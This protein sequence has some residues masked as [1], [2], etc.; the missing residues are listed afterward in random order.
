MKIDMYTKVILT[1]IALALVGIFLKPILMPSTVQAIPQNI[2][3]GFI[4]G[5]GGQ[6]AYA[7]FFFNKDTGQ[8]LVINIAG[9][10]EQGGDVFVDYEFKGF[11]ARGPLK[12]KWI[13]PG[14]FP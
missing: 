13:K 1:I 8:T 9:P 10:P 2:Q 3:T 7:Q 4:P 12:Y 6:D 5:L 14:L 11:R